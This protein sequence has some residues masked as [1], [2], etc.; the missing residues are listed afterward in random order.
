MPNPNS[1]FQNTWWRQWAFSFYDRFIRPAYTKTPSALHKG[2]NSVLILFEASDP[3]CRNAAESVHRHLKEH[4]FQSELVGYFAD[5]L[6]HL[7]GDYSNFNNQS[8]SWLGRPKGD[9]VQ[10]LNELNRH[11]LISIFSQ[12]CLP[13][14]YLVREQRATIKIGFFHKWSLFDVVLDGHHD[15][16]KQAASHI[17][18]FLQTLNRFAHAKS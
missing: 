11:L 18:S 7:E 5:N 1:D 8:L 2:D 4:H 6:E 9:W 17:I 13:L 12:D 16:F 10:P 14:Q 15:T 3:Q